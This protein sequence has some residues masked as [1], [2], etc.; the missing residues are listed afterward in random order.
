MASKKADTL[1]LTLRADQLAEVDDYL[2]K[3]ATYLSCGDDPEQ[4]T[5]AMVE[6][7]TA[8]Q[9]VADILGFIRKAQLEKDRRRAH[10][11]Q[12]LAAE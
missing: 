3:Q 10:F 2:A 6:F 5:A 11:T 1:T 4:L 7:E 9:T 12:Q 8:A